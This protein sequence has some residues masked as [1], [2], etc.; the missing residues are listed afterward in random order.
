MSDKKIPKQ[1]QPQ[2]IEPRTP[3]F[4][5]KKFRNKKLQA[6]NKIDNPAKAKKMVEILRRG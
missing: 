5:V 3:K 6:I 4:D 1:E 2:K